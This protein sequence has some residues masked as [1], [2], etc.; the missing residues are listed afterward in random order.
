MQLLVLIKGLVTTLLL[1]STTLV[2]AES[3]L[4]E[5]SEND[6]WSIDVRG[7]GTVQRIVDGVLIKFDTLTIRSRFSNSDPL[8]I[9]SLRISGTDRTG[10]KDNL[11]SLMFSERAPIGKW[12]VDGETLSLH[13]SVPIFMRNPDWHQKDPRYFLEVGVGNNGEEGWIPV[14]TT[15]HNLQ[16]A[17]NFRRHFKSDVRQIGLASGNAVLAGR[18]AAVIVFFIILYWCKTPTDEVLVGLVLFLF[19]WMGG[20]YPAL[21][22]GYSLLW[23]RTSAQVIDCAVSVT[24]PVGNQTSFSYRPIVK[25]Q[26]AHGAWQFS[27]TQVQLSTPWANYSQSEA[28]A[29]LQPWDRVRLTGSPVPVWVNPLDPSDSVLA[30][31]LSWIE[32][33]WCVV[34]LI[35]ALWRRHFLLLNE[36]GRVLR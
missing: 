16:L 35:Y 11:T 9:T 1:T 23:T 28:Y 19:V 22:F 18:V 27:S 12:L 6:G 17:S 26:F 32:M 21:R 30:R 7:S 4:I 15:L 20:V 29:A 34:G 2:Y 33:F 3:F 36:E 24:P 31:D 8:Y 13:V 5:S 14:D 25:Y 10:E